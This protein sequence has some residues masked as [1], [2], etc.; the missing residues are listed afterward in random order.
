MWGWVVAGRGA[1]G[2]GRGL[3]G[4]N[5][6]CRD[7]RELGGCLWG[8]NGGCG[9][10]RGLGW[11]LWGWEGLGWG[12][13]GWEGVGTEAVGLAKGLW[14]WKVSCGAGMGA[15]GLDV[16]LQWRPWG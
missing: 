16:G 14:G 7:E 15:M 8:R 11:G 13:W 9:A 1:V 6:D 3:R 5:G 12:L 4:W 2:Q 10:G